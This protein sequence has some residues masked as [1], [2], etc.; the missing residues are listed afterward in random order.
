MALLISYYGIRYT[1]GLET[2]LVSPT[3]A[4]QIIFVILPILFGRMEAAGIC[5]EGERCGWLKMNIC[6]MIEVI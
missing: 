3:F 2:I 6:Q 1:E 5:T 4:E